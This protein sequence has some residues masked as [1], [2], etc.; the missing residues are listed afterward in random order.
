MIEQREEQEKRQKEEADKLKQFREQV[1]IFKISLKFE[2]QCLMVF[3]V[4]HKINKFL[5]NETLREYKF[6]PMEKVHRSI[7]WVS[8]QFFHDSI[9]LLKGYNG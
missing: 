2:L 7:V 8:P 4:E 9:K 3:Q 1:R 5:K 6:V